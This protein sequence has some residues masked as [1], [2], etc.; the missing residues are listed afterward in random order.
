[1]PAASLEVALQTLRPIALEGPDLDAYYVE[2]PQSP[3]SRIA[4]QL[5]VQRRLKVLFT[6]HRTTGKSTALNRLAVDLKEEFFVVSLSV[7]KTPGGFR[8][9]YAELLLAMAVRLT[10]QATDEQLWPRSVKALVRDEILEGALRW[11]ES[12]VTE[13]QF[14]AAPAGRGLSGRLNFLVLQIEAK[15]G[16]EPVTREAL[17][18]R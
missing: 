10:A 12:R 16:E 17:R 3:L 13:L 7:L 6:G 14:A 11:F 5:R 15:L 4:R 8:I 1:M 18:E 9:H 2:R